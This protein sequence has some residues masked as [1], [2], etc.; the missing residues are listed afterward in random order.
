MIRYVL[1]SIAIILLTGSLC[2]AQATGPESRI[3]QAKVNEKIIVAAAANIATVADALTS[4]FIAKYP[5]A[6]LDFVFGASGA[7]TTQ[8][9]NGAPYHLFLS[10][11]L[12]FPQ[13]IYAAG[14][15]AAP[16]QVYA[17]G[18]L[19]L[20]SVKTRNFSKGLG[21]LSD[22]EVIQ[23]AMANPEIAPYGKASREALVG[24]GIWDKVKSKV[25][26]AQSISQALQFT[27]G[28]TGLGLIN[29]SALY[30]KDLGI[31]VNK[32][33]VN[34]F[35]LHKDSHG[36]IDQAFVILKPATAN[37]TALAFAAFLMSPEAQAIFLK[38]GYAI[39]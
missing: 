33:G 26:T 30:S 35:E 1:I 37:P 7:L 5:S 13:K 15:A 22:V 34:W 4:A 32:E 29:K 27:L 10:A 6:S 23:F 38:A 9:Q 11:D 39:P 12:D 18:K 31:Y 28:V 16:P 21:L 17:R 8:I 3:D 14:F 24:M 19:I 36:P 20:F 2:L 25:V